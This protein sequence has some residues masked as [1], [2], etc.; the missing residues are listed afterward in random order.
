MISLIFAIIFLILFVFFCIAGGNY[1]LRNMVD[2]ILSK[3]NKE[4]FSNINDLVN[5]IDECKK[6]DMEMQK[7]LNF[8]TATN[9]PLSPNN[10]KNYIGSIYIDDKIEKKNELEDGMYCMKKGKLLYDGIWDPKITNESPYEYESWNLTDGNLTDGY[11]CSDKMIEV[12]KPFPK[13]FIDDSATP[14]ITGGEYYTYFNAE[15]NSINNILILYFFFEFIWNTF[16]K[17]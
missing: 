14:P 7:V 2:N 8:Q 6:T 16:I 9:I 15:V 4:N 1:I 17:N 12:N 3:N 13:N 5:P 11:Y 10:Y